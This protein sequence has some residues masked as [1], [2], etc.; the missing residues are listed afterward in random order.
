MSNERAFEVDEVLHRA[1]NRNPVPSGSTPATLALFATA[2]FEIQQH[3]LR[4]K[5]NEPNYS[6]H[7]EPDQPEYYPYHLPNDEKHGLTHHG[8]LH[9]TVVGRRPSDH[10]PQYALEHHFRDTDQPTTSSHSRKQHQ[11]HDQRVRELH[12][13]APYIQQQTHYQPRQ[14]LHL[15]QQ[16]QRGHDQVRYVFVDEQAAVRSSKRANPIPTEHASAGRQSQYPAHLEQQQQQQRLQY[17]PHEV[18][19]QYTSQIPREHSTGKDEE[20]PSDDVLLAHI[21]LQKAKIAV[22]MDDVNDR[23]HPDHGQKLLH[24]QDSTHNTGPIYRVINSA[25]NKEISVGSAGRSLEYDFKQH[26]KTTHAKRQDALHNLQSATYQ[27]VTPTRGRTLRQARQF[28]VRA[29]AVTPRTHHRLYPQAQ[30]YIMPE[31]YPLHQAFFRTPA[32]LQTSFRKATLHRALTGPSKP[33]SYTPIVIRH[34]GRLHSHAAQAVTLIAQDITT[35]RK[36]LLH[37]RQPSFM[38]S[39]IPERKGYLTKFPFSEQDVT[40]VPS[41]TQD[42]HTYIKKKAA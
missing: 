33:L 34:D 6:H 21:P 3:R 12:S 18:R 30:A 5:H 10:S 42:I 20:E 8:H 4:Q 9:Q 16:H 23:Q 7:H 31:R 22:E 14:D 38:N 2:A 35:D 27:S 40:Q 15:Q 39:V 17:A 37:N 25:D 28:T 11:K 36:Q 41:L 29:S 1:R 13:T 26:P 19:V 32:N 24:Q